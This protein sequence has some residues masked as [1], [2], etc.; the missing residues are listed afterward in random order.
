M[1]GVRQCHFVLCD[2]RGPS[3]DAPGHHDYL[4]KKPPYGASVKVSYVVASQTRDLETQRKVSC[5]LN[6]RP[7]RWVW[8]SAVQAFVDAL[9]R[10]DVH[11]IDR[12]CTD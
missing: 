5:P 6:Y 7:R 3:L 1:R 9:L 11:M 12:Q 8:I 4:G 2:Q 10:L